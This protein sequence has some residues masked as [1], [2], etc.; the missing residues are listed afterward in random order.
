MMFGRVIVSP[1]VT[2][3]LVV[4]QRS[5]CRRI[6]QHPE[7]MQRRV[8]IYFLQVKASS[9]PVRLEEERCWYLPEG[10]GWDASNVARLG[11]DLRI[12]EC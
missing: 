10:V 12:E 2:S 6:L 4:V 7:R 9:G 3:A 11:G 5:D 8:F 1:L